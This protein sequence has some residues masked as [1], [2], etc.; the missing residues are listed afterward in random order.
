MAQTYNRARPTGSWV[1][2]RTG[3]AVNAAAVLS[4][5][6]AYVCAAEAGTVGG[7][8]KTVLLAVGAVLAG[9]TV[10]FGAVQQVRGRRRQ[11][12]AEQIAVDAKEGLSLTLS[13]ALA[14][15]T[16]YLGDLTA[17]QD[18]PSAETIMGQLLQAVVDAAVRL[19]AP[20]SRCAF[21]AL[22]ESATTLVREAY[23]GR[24]ALPRE[25]FRAGTPDGDFV[26]DLVARGD[27]VFVPDVAADPVVTPTTPGAYET[28][29][30]VAV[31]AGSESLGL[32]TVDAPHTGDLSMTDVELVR[33]L[34]N[35]LGSGLGRSE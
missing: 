4:A 1:A 16:K 29:V 28:V 2:D 25:A 15:I 33:V 18:E 35:L 7:G 19:T 8:W 34:A 9:A 30:A 26:L 27:L 20:D 3:L 23:A 5:A 21:Y 24:P 17:A 14:P 32:L 31:T 11:R 22:D 6:G 13:G 12:A 10:A